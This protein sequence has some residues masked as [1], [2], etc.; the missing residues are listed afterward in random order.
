MDESVENINA[1]IN[2]A[3]I[4]TEDNGAKIR[5]T[6]IIL[7]YTANSGGN[8]VGHFTYVLYEKEKLSIV[9]AKLEK[10]R[11]ED[12]NELHM[13]SN[14]YFLNRDK[15]QISKREEDSLDL[16]QIIN[17]ARELNIKRTN[18]LDWTLLIEKFDRGFISTNDNTI[19]YAQFP[20]FKIDVSKIKTKSRNDSIYSN[21]II[22]CKND[23][24][25]LCKSN[26]I[27]DAQIS[28]KLPWLSIFLGLSQRASKE[29]LTSFENSIKYCCTKFQMAEIAF[30]K[31]CI[32][33]R[34]EFLQEI[35]NALNEGTDDIKIMKL[36]KISA[37]Y[38]H[39]YAQ[40]IYFG[41]AIIKKT[42]NSESSSRDHRSE[43]IEVRPG[44]KTNVQSIESEA[45]LGIIHEA[46]N[47][48]NS[49]NRS[50]D[51]GTRVI[52]G[53]PTKYHEDGVVHWQKSLTDFSK[54]GIIGYDKIYPIFQVLDNE[55]RN[56]ILEVLGQRILK[57]N[58]IDITMNLK[59]ED[60]F[61]YQLNK[62]LTEISNIN[63]CQIYASILSENNEDK[64]VYAV[65]VNYVTENTPVIVVHLV[66][67]KKRSKNR[68]MRS[69][70]KS[71]SS[72]IKLC[73][74]IVGPPTS[75]DFD[76]TEFPIVLKSSNCSISKMNK[77]YIASI[78]EHQGCI[79]GTCVLKAAEVKYPNKSKI[80]VGSHF[81][82]EESACLFA[83]NLEN[84]AEPVNDDVVSQRLTLNFCI[85]E[86]NT[87]IP[88]NS[89]F[90]RILVNWRK[91]RN[92]PEIFYG[93]KIESFP[94]ISSCR[95]LIIVNQL[96][97]SC[98]TNCQHG[99]LNANSEDFIYGSINSQRS[100]N[101]KGKVSYL[102]IPFE[103][104]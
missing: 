70:N 20:A 49:N 97:N 66:Q 8:I 28:A 81:T 9:R 63:E 78:P 30:S 95:R 37:N 83:Y 77:Q 21:I 75:F 91:S 102:L 44:V 22:E 94:D 1:N 51:S 23:F 11:N 31:S 5:I 93:T 56:K 39:F 101:D 48:T 69:R 58:I 14:C 62:E 85:V 50:V 67:C 25:V 29:K 104:Q 103:S 71:N 90:G 64:K 18:D 12:S 96:F 59:S 10:E 89:N 35:D 65:H 57:A 36:R 13:G 82:G 54:W 2:T 3:C 55:R 80:V 16:S 73:W 4:R 60:P 98:S 99:F 42:I 92:Q 26:F 38:G 19:A 41:G 6:I 27:L 79:L 47:Q 88:E 34:D 33:P 32:T 43:S 52:G 15:I 46:I 86:A 7:D 24:E 40:R 100:A 17:D 61:I 87:G 76:L 68:S 53:D 74:I 84:R 72:S 45:N